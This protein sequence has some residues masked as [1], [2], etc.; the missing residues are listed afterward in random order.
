MDP[1][2]KQGFEPHNRRHQ[3]H[4]DFMHIHADSLTKVYL[5]AV[6]GWVVCLLLVKVIR[7]WRMNTQL[8]KDPTSHWQN[9]Q[10]LSSNQ[11]WLHASYVYSI[12]HALTLIFMNVFSSF[13]CQPP[14][15]FRSPEGTFL[16]NTIYTNE[17]C[18][19]NAN[20]WECATLCIFT[21]YLTVDFFVCYFL[22]ADTSQGAVENYLHHVIGVLGSF[23]AFVVGRSIMTLS[24]ATC[25][26]EFSTPFVSLR[27]LLS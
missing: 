7:D 10:K 1:V 11:K 9:I 14:T 22:I 13:Q 3:S 24:N 20:W 26:T 23:S 21:G 25:L 8:A 6:I 5:A 15:A 4:F 12:I 18:V 17:W 19:D 2:Y 16:G 27:G